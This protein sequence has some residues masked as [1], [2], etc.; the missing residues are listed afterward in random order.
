MKKFLE[1][2]KIKVVE[3]I[4][5]CSNC[6]F[7]VSSCPLY[8]GWFTQ[9]APGKM[10]ALYYLVKYGYGSLEEVQKLI[11]YCTTCGNCERVC[12]AASSYVP[13]IENIE[14]ARAL[15]VDTEFGPL[16][17][18]K[19]F[20]EHIKKEHNPYMEKHKERFNWL[21]KE[22]LKRLPKKAE[23]VYF[24]GCT[25]SYRQKEI[26]KA[27][28]DVFLKL[29]VD[30][31]VLGL[32]EWCC[33]SPLLRT[34]QWN[35]AKELAIHNRDVLAKL[36]ID[37]II[38]TCAGCYRTFKVDYKEKYRDILEVDF[39]FKIVHTTE[40][41]W[42]LTKKGELKFK[43][44]YEKTI[45]YHDPCHLGRHCG[46]YDAPREI[47]KAIPN[48]KLIEMPRTREA[49][50]CCGAGGGFRSGY[51]DVSLSVAKERLK[52]AESIGVEILAS[53]CPFCWRNLYDAT[54]NSKSKIVIKDIV[55]I[56]SE[57]L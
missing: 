30:F 50:W 42:N 32:D 33:G 27:T 48:L 43:S 19:A 39:P 1:T 37:K 44:K 17:K 52:E 12:K 23:Y 38:T 18:Q 22:V 16:L 51:P 46:V 34:G 21:S 53:A 26:A 45:T 6:K 54:E 35:I 49:A 14:K 10:R 36:E 40:L 20:G 41:L 8:R 31:T 15:L 3:D 25:S 11:Y 24:V 28:V 7:C 4:Q 2:P 56:V 57:A 13:V 9:A 5:Q 47:L 29:G 55:Q